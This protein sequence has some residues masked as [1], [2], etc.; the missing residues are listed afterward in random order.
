MLQ[1]MESPL[2]WVYCPNKNTFVY[3]LIF[4][5]G[6]LTSN[7]LT[8]SASPPWC[9]LPALLLQ[10]CFKNFKRDPTHNFHFPV[11]F[12]HPSLPISRSFIPS[13][14]PDPCGH[15]FGLALLL[16]LS[17]KRASRARRF[18]HRS[19][20]RVSLWR[21]SRSTADICIYGARTIDLGNIS[22]AFL[23]ECVSRQFV[24][25]C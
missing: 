1:G 13:N 24:S 14:P 20:C 5:S 22:S 23:E 8:S 17:L 16:Q 2:K 25:P 7:L 9:S 4:Q 10:V 19:R 11:S 21:G 15:I 3:P 12:Y 18:W 6:F